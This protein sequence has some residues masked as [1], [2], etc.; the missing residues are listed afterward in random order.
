[1]QPTSS[2]NRRC[3]CSWS[4]IG[5]FRTVPPELPTVVERDIT[6]VAG[7]IDYDRCSVGDVRKGE[8]TPR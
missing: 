7:H 3:C 8:A 2:S 1:M 5:D 6:G 4:S